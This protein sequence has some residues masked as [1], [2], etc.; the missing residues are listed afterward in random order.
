M[1]R[2]TVEDCIDLIPNRYELVIIAAQRAKDIASGAPLTLERDN[3]KDSVVSLREIAEKTVSI[4]NLKEEVIESYS[5]LRPFERIDNRPRGQDVDMASEVEDDIED[6]QFKDNSAQ[7]AKS[8][9]SFIDENI[10][11]ED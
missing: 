1:A 11:V 6:H 8:G 10:E 2:I 9:M 3:D 7:L 4:E 5:G